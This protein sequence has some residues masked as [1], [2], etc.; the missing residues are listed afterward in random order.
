MHENN[1]IIIEERI[2]LY[3]YIM[4]NTRL[5]HYHL[6]TNGRT[7]QLAILHADYEFTEVW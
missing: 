4:E 7:D 2:G 3:M 5:T 1:I 6:W